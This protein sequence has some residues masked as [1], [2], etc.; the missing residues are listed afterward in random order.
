VKP[1]CFVLTCDWKQIGQDAWIEP[2]VQRGGRAHKQLVRFYECTRCK[3][4]KATITSPVDVESNFSIPSP[5]HSAN[6]TRVNL[7]PQEKTP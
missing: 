3:D 1:L 2:E 7:V 4:T 6:F 5:L